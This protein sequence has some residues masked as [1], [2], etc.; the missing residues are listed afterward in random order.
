MISCV[1]SL[2]IGI[3]FLAPAFQYRVELGAISFTFLEPIA[4]AVI[5]I[6]WLPQVLNR[7][8]VVIWENLLTY[9]LSSLSLWAFVVGTLAHDWQH[10]LS[11]ARDWMIPMLSFIVLTSA[12]S[13]Y[14][15]RWAY[16]FVASTVTSAALGVYQHFARIIGPFAVESV[17]YKTGFAL[18][19]DQQRLAFAVPA[20]AFF[21]HPNLLA[22]YLFSGLVILLSWRSCGSWGLLK[23]ILT[24]VVAVGL[25]FTYAKAIL[26]IIPFCLVLLWLIYRIRTWGQFI[27][28]VGFTILLSA[29]GVIFVL[30]LIPEAYFDT[31]WWRVDLWRSA[32][33]LLGAHPGYLLSGNG[34]ELFASEALYPQPHNLY[35]YLLLAYGIPGLVLGL[36][37]LVY[38]L[39]IARQIHKYGLFRQQ[40]LLAGFWVGLLAYFVVGFVEST[41][42][43]IESRMFFALLNALLIGFAREAQQDVFALCRIRASKFDL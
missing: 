29:F 27:W 31:F 9:L 23:W 13:G 43:G 30:P 33:D 37:I 7:Q 36:C 39:W 11:D 4:I 42:M 19:E 8:R 16:V 41:L 2:L 26:L 38:L 32:I 12:V 20:T 34:L 35:L 24:L 15:K 6:L 25:F 40:P 17:A 18:V 21:S 5:V 3:L 28:G 10:G 14:W 1:I 22:L